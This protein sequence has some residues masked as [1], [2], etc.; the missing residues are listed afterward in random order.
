M[1]RRSMQSITDY[2][3]GTLAFTKGL[4]PHFEIVDIRK[5]CEAVIELTSA[6][7]KQRNIMLQMRCTCAKPISADRVLIERMLA[8]IVNNA[9]DAS[10]ADQT[11]SL[12]AVASHSD[13]ATFEV[14]DNGSGILP[15]D[16]S[17]I[18]DPYFTTKNVENDC[19]GIGLGLTIVSNIVFLHDGYIRVQSEPGFQTIVSVEIPYERIPNLHLADQGADYGR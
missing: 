7:A 6:R 5:L 19:R 16:K 14:H 3:Q 9:I 10:S 1:A 12:L 11:V 17:R 4:E 8:N 2:V 18:F 13:R 15:Q